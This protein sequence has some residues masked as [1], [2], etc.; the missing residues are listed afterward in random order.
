MNFLLWTTIVIASLGIIAMVILL[1][2]QSLKDVFATMRQSAEKM[3]DRWEE[4]ASAELHPITAPEVYDPG[5][6]RLRWQDNKV[7]RLRR[8]NLRHQKYRKTWQKWLP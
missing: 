4:H 8:K 1:C 3:R 5:S 6:A 7:E 2:W